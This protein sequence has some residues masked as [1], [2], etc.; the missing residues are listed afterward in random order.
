MRLPPRLPK[1]LVIIGGGYIAMEFAHV[2]DALGTDVTIIARST[3]LRNLDEDLH[4]PFN[5]LAVERFDIRTGRT[6]IGADQTDQGIT[7]RLDDGSSATGEVL[8]V[9]TGR[10]PPNGDLLDLPPAG[11]RR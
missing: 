4:G 5:D 9:A 2:F 1:S 6:T 7:V 3:L 11:S 10:I 8:L